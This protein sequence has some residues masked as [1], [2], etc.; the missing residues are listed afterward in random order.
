M[1]DEETKVIE[2]DYP[3]LEARIQQLHD[4][5]KQKR[6]RRKELMFASNYG[7]RRDLESLKQSLATGFGKAIKAELTQIN[8][9]FRKLYRLRPKN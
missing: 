3:K 1:K 5:G 7:M 4:E 2:M 9:K 8:R 6:Q